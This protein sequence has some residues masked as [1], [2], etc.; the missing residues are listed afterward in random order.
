MTRTLIRTA[1]AQ[2]LCPVWPR[3]RSGRIKWE[4]A[5]SARIR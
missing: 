2:H 4:G 5:R 1:P 3:P